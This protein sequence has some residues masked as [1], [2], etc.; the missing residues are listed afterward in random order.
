MAEAVTMMTANPA[1]VMGLERT[2]NLDEIKES[3]G[4]C[5]GSCHF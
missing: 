1:W 3:G 2:G 4:S 5:I